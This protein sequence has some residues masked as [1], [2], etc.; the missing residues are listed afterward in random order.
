VTVGET[1]IYL[2][3]PQAGTIERELKDR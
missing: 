1:P 2:M 3:A